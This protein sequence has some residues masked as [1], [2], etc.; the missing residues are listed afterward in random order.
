MADKEETWED[1]IGGEATISGQRV[2]FFV[3]GSYSSIQCLIR[4]F[5]TI[6]PIVDES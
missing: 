6:P 4:N 3:D 1:N 5:Y 2:S